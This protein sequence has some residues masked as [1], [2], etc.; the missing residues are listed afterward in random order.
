M[1]VQREIPITAGFG[2]ELFLKSENRKIAH[3]DPVAKGDGL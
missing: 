2:F 1:Q 3:D